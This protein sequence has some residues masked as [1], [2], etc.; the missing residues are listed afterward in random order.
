MITNNSPGAVNNFAIANYGKKGDVLTVR[1][2]V[3]CDQNSISSPMGIVTPG[4][5]KDCSFAIE[6]TDDAPQLLYF[7]ATTEEQVNFF[8]VGITKD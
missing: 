2:D 8:S 3:E 7:Q 1:L 5:A 4:M 6:I